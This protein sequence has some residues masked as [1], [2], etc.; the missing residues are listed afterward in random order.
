MNYKKALS[1]LNGF[2][3]YEKLTY[4]NYKGAYNLD[5][6]RRLLLLLDNPQDRFKS[7]IVAGTKGKGSTASIISSILS[8]TG[9]RVGFYS[10]PHLVSLRERIQ[11]NNKTITEPEFGKLVVLIKKVVETNGLKKITY[12]EFLTALCFLY[13]AKKK[14][15]I[16]ILEVGL[17]GRLDATNTVNAIISVITP[18]SYDHI[19]LL[20][21]SLIE[22]SKEK[23]GVIKPYTFVIT[24][25]QPKDVIRIIK[26]TASI[27]NAKV[28]VVG[29]DIKLENLK[30]NLFGTRFDLRS[31]GCH[32][33]DL[34]MPFI[35]RHQAINAITALAAISLLK[36]KFAFN[37]RT[38]DIRQGLKSLNFPGRFQVVFERPYIV[39]DGAQNAASAKRLRETALGLFKNKKIFLIL[40]SSADKDIEGMGRAL[41][42]ISEV[43]IFTRADSPRAADPA[44]LAQ[45]L[46]TFCK[47]SYVCT[48]IRDALLFAKAFARKK[49]VILVTGSL[50]LVGDV[51]RS[52]SS[53][54]KRGSNISL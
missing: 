22:I 54:R 52:L 42:P 38:C 45:R 18:I 19:D 39:L 25:P 21:K 33:K 43:V 20:G 15:D 49:D 44:S 9:V 2:I 6:V 17:G 24:A 29:R 16:A 14:V 34:K 50:F 46:S 37:V 36:E 4:Y 32:Y 12:F 35:G 53:P 10:S 11:I 47:D 26:D 48:D 1:Y 27:N 23:C 13:F 7:I 28:L 40:G 8:G 30:V 31:K 51:L 3:D 5:R 41:C